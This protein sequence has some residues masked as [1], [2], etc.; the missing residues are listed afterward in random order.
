MVDTVAAFRGDASEARPV[1]DLDAS[2]PLAFRVDRA[3]AEELAAY[4]NFA[5]SAVAAPAQYGEWTTA[6]A[7]NAAADAVLLS[8]VVDSRPVF[9]LAL[10]IVKS[11]PLCSARFMGGNH[12][13]GNFPALDSDALAG[14]SPKVLDRLFSA[15]RQA[16]PDVDLIR[17]ERMAPHIGAIANPLLQLPHSR[18]PN[19][20]LAVDLEG[21][22][23]GVLARTS[24]KRKRKKHRSQTRKF[25]AAGGFQRIEARTPEQVERLLGAFFEMKDARFR[26]MGVRNVFA[27]PA[28]RRFFVELFSASLI[29]RK[30]RYVLHGLDVG[31]KLRA[32]TGASRCGNRMICEFGAIGEDELASASPGEFLFFD[33]IREAAEQG[34]ALY[35]F[36]VGD[37][38]YK[39]LWC[40][41]EMVQHDVLVALSARGRLWR[42]GLLLSANA[43][44]RIKNSP[45]L[46]S[47][48]KRLRRQTSR[49]P[50]AAEAPD[51]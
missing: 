13:N 16:R 33:N 40:N 42:S 43:K 44:T 11:G 31:G 50:E 46:W 37:E 6:W 17:L 45:F 25:E 8:V 27:D 14:I 2:G 20:A 39:R 51:D 28:V 22:F 7:N 18:S 26:K 12:A 38:P 34:F 36:S 24:G 41:V 30:P 23:D 4:A 3:G 5:Q 9:T 47:L 19:L 49:A 15:F 10:E 48:I 21:G 32:V 1:A 29:S 35:D